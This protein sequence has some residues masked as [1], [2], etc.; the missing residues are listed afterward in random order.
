MYFDPREVGMAP[1]PFKYTVFNS[2]VV[3]RP[4]GW[5]TTIDV[6]GVINLAPFSFFNAISAAPP[7]VIYCPSYFKPGFD[8]PE[9]SLVNVKATGEFVYN[10]CTHDLREK[11]VLTTKQSPRSP[12]EFT[13]VG[14]EVA[15]CHQVKPPRVKEAPVALECK[16]VQS[17][18]LPATE[19]GAAAT[20]VIGQVV[21]IH[22]SDD[23]ITEDGLVDMKKLRPLAR[24]GY[25]DFAVIEPEQIFSMQAPGDNRFVTDAK[26]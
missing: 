15:S 14:L 26:G 8:E 3:P 24:L 17:I 10:M 6:D 9:P 20:A 23:V 4:I 13:N 5:I 7:C 19:D 22:I 2:L 11:M 21:G 1:P 12:K 16:Y 18:T 25:H